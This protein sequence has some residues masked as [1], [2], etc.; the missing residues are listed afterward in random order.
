MEGQLVHIHP[1]PVPV[2]NVD[3]TL[4]EALNGNGTPCIGMHT[5][6]Q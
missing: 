6:I 4:K 2:T 5:Y 1:I 3:E